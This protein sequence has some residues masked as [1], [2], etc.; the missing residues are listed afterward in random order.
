LQ[1]SPSLRRASACVS[2]PSPRRMRAR[3]GTGRLIWRSAFAPEVRTQSL[4]RDRFVG[5]ARIG[6]PLLSGTDI[7]PERYAACAHVVASRKGKFNG[8]VDDALEE[9]GLRRTSCRDFLMRCTSLVARISSR[10]CRARASAIAWKTIRQ[11]QQDF[12]ASSFRFARR[13]S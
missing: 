9:L 4:F 11:R 13:R 6:H 3:S 10:S 1:L 7:T 12:R 8:P 2:R 5:V